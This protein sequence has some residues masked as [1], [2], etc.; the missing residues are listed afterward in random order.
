MARRGYGQGSVFPN[1]EGPGYIAAIELPP[2]ADGRRRRVRR[3]HPTKAAAESALEELREEFRQ[4][5]RILNPNRRV[6]DA[7]TAFAELRDGKRISEGTREEDAYFAEIINEILGGTRLSK[8]TVQDCDRFLWSISKDGD[9][10]RS[11]GPAHVGKIRNRL[12]A[13]LRN[14][15]R[16]GNLTINVAELSDPPTRADAG[17]LDAYDE[18]SEEQRALTFEELQALL[19]VATGP[20]LVIVDLCGRNALRPAE[21]RALRWRDVDLAGA[22]LSVRAQQ[23]RSNKRT[24]TKRANNA[25]RTIGLDAITVSRLASWKADQ[26]LAAAAAGPLWNDQDLVATTASGNPIDRRNLARSVKSLCR[27][28]GLEDPITPYELRHTAISHQADQGRDAWEIADWAGTSEEMISRVYRH[29]LRRVAKL[30]PAHDADS[31]LS[32]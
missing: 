2:T 4:T 20:R 30:R 24:R 32:D 12:V 18:E 10:R 28:A 31:H 9:S 14:E 3:K 15:M 23:S 1:P 21:A 16:V 7:V 5:G 27:R 13:I 19:A 29:R 17:H 6:A 25:A 22:E 11:I 26:E 8:L